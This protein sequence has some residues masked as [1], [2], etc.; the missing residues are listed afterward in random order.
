MSD[1]QNPP[2]LESIAVIGM[3]GRFPG[4]KNIAEF[5]AMLCEG[6]EG[7]SHFSREELLQGGTSPEAQDDPDFVSASSVISDADKFDADFF[8]FSPNEARLMDP[9]QRLFLETAYHALETSGYAPDL[10]T[11]PISVYAG[12]A[13]N[14]YFL[15][16]VV[17]NAE[18]RETMGAYPVMLLNDKDYLATRVSYKL[19]LRGASFT[20]QTA[21]STSLVAVHQAC[22]ALLSYS[23]DLA[24]AGGVAVHSPRARGYLYEEGMIF[25]PDGRCRPFDSEA[26]GTVPGEGVGVVVLKR[27]SEALADGDTIDA[28]ILGSALNNDGGN[29]VG[30]SA[31]SVNGQAEV[32]ATAQAV[33]GVA[34][35]TISYVEAHGTGTLLGDPIELAALTQAFRMGTDETQF[36]A[37]GSVKSNIGHPDVAAGV[38]GLIKT[39]LCLKH[40]M[41]TPTPHFSK[42]NPH[43][44]FA[45]SPFF[46]NTELRE[47][48]SLEGKPRRAGVSSF[49]IGGTN[50]HA[51][52]QEAPPFVPSS[53]NTRRFLPLVLSAKTPEV[54]SEMTANLKGWLKEQT[55]DKTA[56]ADAAYTL[57]IGRNLLPYRR[58]LLFDTE[59]RSLVPLTPT[60]A[61]KP[62]TTPPK[63]AFLFPGQ[64]A[65][66]AGMARSLYTSEPDFKAHVD[67]CAEFLKPL[68][69]A[70]LREMMFPEIGEDKLEAANESL[71]ETRFAQPALFIV[72]IGIAKLWMKWGV[73]PDAMLGHSVG[74]YAAACL[75]G[76]ISL[77]DALR[78]IAARGNMMSSIEAGGMLA[79]RVGANA[80]L[81]FLPDTLEVAADNAPDLCVVSGKQEAI[82]VF[83]VLCKEREIGCQKLHTSHAFHSK[84]M[85]P[86]LSNFWKEAAKITDRRAKFY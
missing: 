55:D 54:L 14:T 43:F 6:R 63:I 7:I 2:E 53:P 42:P 24:L 81:E 32:I 3:A 11:G 50:A 58:A 31:P 28:V 21:C 1:E 86:I 34:P 75:S 25:S 15:N 19:N 76:A 59:S 61:T 52:L 77:E 29:K 26:K 37:L 64:G 17:T 85:E 78:L 72:S 51:I 41:L 5:W 74:E 27:L 49:G 39:V 38:I 16:N 71:K 69:G 36:C 62:C 47:W 45:M 13:Y 20:V 56:F 84:M 57:A 40:R 60:P 70:D 35:E 8:S 10:Y 66:F 44:D 4:A 23:C 73:A 33:A 46:V 9:Q 22:A 83:A 67:E 12:A 82:E 68:L 48:T 65:Q 79:V 30:F 18:V 80:V